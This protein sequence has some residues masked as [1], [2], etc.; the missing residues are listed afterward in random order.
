LEICTTVMLN[1]F[2]HPLA[3][4]FT[5]KAEQAPYNRTPKRAA[6]IRP[7]SSARVIKAKVKPAAPAG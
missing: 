5:N 4:M 7:E 1:L 6:T 2:Q 3:P